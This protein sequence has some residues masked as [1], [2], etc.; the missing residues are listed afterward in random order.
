VLAAPEAEIPQVDDD[1]LVP[2]GADDSAE[3]LLGARFDEPDA[4]AA[5]DSTLDELP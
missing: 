1:L 2:V 4:G 3:D 5:D